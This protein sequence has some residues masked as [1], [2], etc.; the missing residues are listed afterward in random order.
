LEI[1]GSALPSTVT[2]GRY[3]LR[4]KIPLSDLRSLAT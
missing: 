4:R 2:P 1:I 3:S